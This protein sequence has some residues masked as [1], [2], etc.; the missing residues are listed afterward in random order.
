MRKMLRIGEKNHDTGA[1]P[2]VQRVVE[3]VLSFD[4]LFAGKSCRQ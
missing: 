3:Q 4:I 1:I 2:V